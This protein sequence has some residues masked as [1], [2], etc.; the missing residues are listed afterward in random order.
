M[1]KRAT[2]FLAGTVTGAA[3]SG[4]AKRRVR[5]AVSQVTPRAVA[6]QG[7]VALRRQATRLVRREP[8]HTPQ[9][10]ADRI[11]PDEQVLVDGRPVDRERIVVTRHHLL[12][13]P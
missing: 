2:W 10:L 1:L 9:S 6:R 12:P 4:Y 11:A 3:G 7:A 13:G 5:A 8:N